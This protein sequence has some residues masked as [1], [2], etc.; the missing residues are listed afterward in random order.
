M[1]VCKESATGTKSKYLILKGY[2]LR[3]WHNSFTL[4]ALELSIDL[5]M[6]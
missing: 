3:S 5:S 2:N 6:R 4:N 1:N